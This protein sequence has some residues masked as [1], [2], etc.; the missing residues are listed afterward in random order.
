MAV[1]IIL[2]LIAALSAFILA[3]IVFMRD[4]H[5]FV[6][7]I[8]ATGMILLAFEAVM[9][10]FTF[11]APY[12]KEVLIWQ[13]IRLTDAAVIPSIWLLFSL[14]YARLNYK[15][16]LSRWRWVVLAAFII[17]VT[18]VIFFWKSFFISVIGLDSPSAW[19][20][21][22]GWS[23]YAFQ[24]CF[25]ISVVLILMN[26][27][28]TL[29]ASVGHL[30]WQIKYMVLGIGSIF[31]IRIYTSSQTILFHS[32]NTNLLMINSG[33][34]ILASALILRSL[35]RVGSLNIDF[36][37]SHTF[38]YNSF[39]VLIV[40][41]YLLAIGVLAKFIQYLNG[42][43]SFYLNT[44]LIFL[45]L[46]GLSIILLSDRLRHKIKRFIAIHLK[47]PQFD[48]QKVW[49]KF[50]EKTS[51]IT[52]VK[53]L[54]M[55]VCRMISDALEVLSVTMWLLEESHSRLRPVGSTVFSEAGLGHRISEEGEAKLIRAME[56]LAM[57]VDL[58]DP[59]ISWA[60]D[61][62]QSM[63]DS[64]QEARVRYCVPLSAGENFLGVMTLGDKV[65]YASFS[66]EEMS[67][68]KTIADQTAASL[69]NL[70][71]SE[72][73]R[74]AK[75]ME[76][77]QTMST[78]VVHDLKNLA[79]TLSLTMQNLPIHFDNPDF[80]SDALRVMEQGVSKINRMCNH[81]SML[82]QKIELKKVET[83]MHNL[84]ST[85]LTCLNGSCKVSLIQDLR[86]MSK[87]MIDPEQVQKVLTN[88][89]LN[90]KE[91]VG[92]GGEIRL[93]I[94]QKDEWAILSVSDNGCGMSK[95]FIEYS[96]FRPFKTTKKQG[97]GIGLFQSKMIVE[98]HQG[99]IEVESKEGRGT[100]FRV[101]LP[102]QEKR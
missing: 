5:S 68:L 78:F 92:N 37:L 18:L 79:S 90:A 76:A 73:L 53:D 46:L 95:E 70:K 14:A 43:T 45:A 36:Y 19:I 35:L 72:D 26:L 54:C 29:R 21:R 80:R 47:R 100:T 99:S 40:G 86:L 98:A 62:K 101:L 31:G 94:E 84:I 13:R 10:A 56:D 33:V 69:L 87:L 89:I 20:I 2:S 51:T 59:K 61:L 82:S 65:E 58:D 30:R 102:L 93:A 96:L 6:H 8:F 27:E 81:L 1:N 25:L 17:P 88:L 41:I 12:S 57:P 28:R 16:I 38:L 44:F 64:I 3:A 49:M 55:T 34:L 91:A 63:P 7:W 11:F 85:C 60:H 52:D 9:S 24:L 77:F 97:M 83:D 23:G 48:Y 74:K 42:G 22:L 4:R 50:T 32:L 39:T 75:E 66:F 71:L 67:L 15:E